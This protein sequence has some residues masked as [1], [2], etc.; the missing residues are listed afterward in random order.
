MQTTALGV[1]LCMRLFARH[2]EQWPCPISFCVIFA[3]LLCC[4]Y[5]IFEQLC[6]WMK[7]QNQNRAGLAVPV[8]LGLPP[9]ERR[10]TPWT[11]CQLTEGLRER[12]VLR[13]LRCD[14]TKENI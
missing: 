5:C 9:G 11:G 14:G 6:I 7:I 10:G 4:F 1:Y 2:G 3:L 12:D 8:S 13:D